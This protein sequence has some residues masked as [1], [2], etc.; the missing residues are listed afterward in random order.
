MQISDYK[1]QYD[2][3]RKNNDTLKMAELYSQINKLEYEDVYTFIRKANCL[4]SNLFWK[5]DILQKHRELLK[6]DLVDELV[7]TYFSR[8][9]S[10]TN[11]V[12]IISSEAPE[13]LVYYFRLSKAFMIDTHFESIKSLNKSL[14]E[15]TQF[16]R[17]LLNQWNDKLRFYNAIVSN[18]SYEDILIHSVSYFEKYKRASFGLE[19]TSN[20]FRMKLINLC[21]G[22]NKL[23]NEKRLFANSSFNFSS[24]ELKKK[25]NNEMPPLNPPEGIIKQKYIPIEEISKEKKI[26]RETIDFYIRLTIFEHRFDLY[27][28][29]YGELIIK[30]QS[31]GILLMNK[32]YHLHLR[33]DK[34][35][36]GLRTFFTNKS[37]GSR[38]F[39][40]RI[41]NAKEGYEKQLIQAMCI[42]T[43]YFK[44]LGIGNE[45]EIEG[46][47]LEIIDVFNVLY[48]FSYFLK[49]DQKDI[50]SPQKENGIELTSVIKRSK[51]ENFKKIF[52]PD[53][54]VIFEENELL[55]KIEKYF[56]F[57]MENVK[58]II[59]F[60]TLDLDRLDQKEMDLLSCPIIK[61]SDKYFWLS[62]L[63]DDLDWMM[64][65]Y[66]KIADERILKHQEQSFQIEKNIAESFNKIDIR[67]VSS[68]KYKNGHD[69]GEIDAIAYKDKKLLIFEVKTTYFTEDVYRNAFYNYKTFELTAVK[70]LENAKEYI[71]DN[72]EEFRK[73]AN[74]NIDCD[75]SDLTIEC[76]IVSNIFEYD[77]VFI[78]N[79][80]LKLSLFELYVIL[81]NDLFSVLN[82]DFS[83][84]G[85]KSSN[86]PEFLLKKFLNQNH[87]MINPHAEIKTD[88]ESCDLS[89]GK[90][91]CDIND[92]ILSIRENKV[93]KHLDEQYRYPEK[94]PIHIGI[95]TENE[96][97]LIAN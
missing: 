36:D 31:N 4:N 49:P 55:E 12:S 66:K 74:I 28:C 10:Y 84:L 94:I 51:P 48:A 5:S 7:M 81:N 50:I 15:E 54:F 57:S 44:F 92:I 18:I 46:K 85:F 93:W 8:K 37:L 20:T 64:H 89:N 70:Q 71:L 58:A 78:K 60:L 90:G 6:S 11:I 68:L 2:L 69:D 38:E 21:Y 95:Y 39:N 53:Y 91:K 59:S 23:F 87:P 73:N 13:K 88:K 24:S 96:K 79:K 72:F 43:E 29:G 19:N 56:S 9:E 14:Y 40:E 32:K 30:N 35:N 75:L 61:K 77:D 83:K 62:S 25:F 80:F 34:K 27:C 33:N 45:I 63:Y 67:A 65:I 82:L 3:F 22:L 47:S 76:I 52:E 17:S 1:N 86:I 16:L 97:F 42:G 26:I 41:K